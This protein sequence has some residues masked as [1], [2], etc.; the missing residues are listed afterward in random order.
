MKF[1]KKAL[2]LVL[3]FLLI[4]VSNNDYFTNPIIVSS[5]SIELKLQDVDSPADRILDISYLFAHGF[6]DIHIENDRYRRIASDVI[7]IE[8]STKENKPRYLV[9][10]SLIKGIWEHLKLKTVFSKVKISIFD[11][12]SGETILSWAVPATGWSGDKTG[13]KLAELMQISKKYDLNKVIKSTNSTSELIFSKE[14]RE[15]SSIE[16]DELYKENT[17]SDK[18]K[19]TS[20]KLIDSHSMLVASEWRFRLP[21]NLREITCNQSGIFISSSW[22][23][24]DLYLIWLNNDGTFKFSS[25][26]TAKRTKLGGSYYPSKL[27]SVEFNGDKLL[28]HRVFF[29]NIDGKNQWVIDKEIK[30]TI[31]IKNSLL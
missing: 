22:Q 13:K 16:L 28:A 26:V 20:N 9:T 10:Q 25:Y 31:P 15:L 19:V 5:E 29:K 23:P 7:Y 12:N 14:L 27:L 24:E 21:R 2:V 17:C 11:R 4:L 6:N 30:Y 3:I 8:L 1:N 18:L